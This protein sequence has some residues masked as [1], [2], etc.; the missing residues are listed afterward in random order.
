ML[1]LS[2]RSVFSIYSE[3]YWKATAYFQWP[4]MII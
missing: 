3:E 4:L 1:E 2:M